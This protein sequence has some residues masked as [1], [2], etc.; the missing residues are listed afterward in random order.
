MPERCRMARWMG[1]RRV[2]ERIAGFREHCPS[3]EP[4]DE[5]IPFFITCYEVFGLHGLCYRHQGH[6][7]TCEALQSF[8]GLLTPGVNAEQVC[9]LILCPTCRIV[10]PKASDPARLISHL[11]ITG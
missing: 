5:E 6:R 3:S 11:T 10:A 2:T 8:D 7:A 4:V 1:I 9:N